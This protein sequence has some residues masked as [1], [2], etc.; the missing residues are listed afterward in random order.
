MVFFSAKRRNSNNNNYCHY[1]LQLT[2][3]PSC[4]LPVVGSGTSAV[5]R[6]R[7]RERKKEFE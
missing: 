2:A 7:E 1:G 4:R 6:G 3:A 5:Q